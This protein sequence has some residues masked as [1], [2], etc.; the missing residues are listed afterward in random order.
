[1]KKIIKLSLLLILVIGCGEEPKK[2]SAKETVTASPKSDEETPAQTSADYSSLFS[3][4][5][6]DMNLTELAKV[7]KVPEADLSLGD[8]AKQDKCTFNLV[9]FGENALSGDTR[10]HWGPSPSSKAQNKKDIKS[11]LE[12][13][14]DGIK[15]M[16]MDIILAETEDCY[17][18]YQ[19]AHGRVIIYNENYDSAFL[20]NYGQKK[21]NNVR[22]DEQHEALRLKMTDLANYLV[23]K[24]R[25]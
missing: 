2:Q 25:K 9:G 7:L 5:T 20:L 12:R 21:V 24:N 4:Y 19:P 18:A 1:M 22:T 23:K 16:G 6:C 10:L 17:I 15:I 13:K 11:Y 3:E 8:Q 14:K